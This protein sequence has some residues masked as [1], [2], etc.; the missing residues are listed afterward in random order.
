MKFARNISKL[1]LVLALAVP[2]SGFA[3]IES[4]LKLGSTGE[5]VTL[6]QEVLVE[7]GHLVMPERADF[8]YF[9]QMTKEALSEWQALNG[10]PSTG[11]FGSMSREVLNSLTS[12]VTVGGEV[13]ASTSLMSAT[14]LSV[15]ATPHPA[16]PE[17]KVI[18]KSISPTRSED[19]SVSSATSKL[20]IKITANDET[21]YLNGDNESTDDLQFLN[22][23]VYG[24]GIS[25][26]T[27]ATTTS[28]EI[29]SGS[30]YAVSNDG[31]DDEYYTLDAGESMVIEIT[32]KLT[33]DAGTGVAVLAGVKVDVLRF[34]ID[35]VSDTTRGAI[36][37]SLG[38]L[39]EQMQSGTV[40]LLHE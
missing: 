22:V 33:Q 31:T 26:S 17:V 19:G 8:G 9:G 3:Y 37:M 32:S 21:I 30:D 5:E 1:A 16:S 20:K 24:S 10:L 6:L 27:T 39:G 14:L 38:E 29:T 18:S 25:A 13:V 4:D 34:G 12:E 23:S 2:V 40:E 35:D 15:R 36:E 7:E 11:Y 28:Y